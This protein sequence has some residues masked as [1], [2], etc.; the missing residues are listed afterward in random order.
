MAGVFLV[1]A[2]SR[3]HPQHKKRLRSNIII[4]GLLLG[5]VALVFGI[6][7]VK[8]SN[9]AMLEAFD[10]SYRISVTPAKDE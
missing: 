1:M 3:L 9:G 8:M 4:G 7:V 5:F 10:H 2:L 6:T